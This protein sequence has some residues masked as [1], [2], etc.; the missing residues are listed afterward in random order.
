MHWCPPKTESPAQQASQGFSSV[1]VALSFIEDIIRCRFNKPW[2]PSSCHPHLRTHDLWMHWGE[3]CLWLLMSQMSSSGTMTFL[4]NATVKQRHSIQGWKIHSRICGCQIFTVWTG[5][6]SELQSFHGSY[7][8][9]H[10][11]VQPFCFDRTHHS[12]IAAHAH[13]LK[14]RLLQTLNYWV[15]SAAHLSRQNK[16]IQLIVC[17]WFL[18]QWCA[19]NNNNNNLH[20]KYLRTSSSWNEKYTC[21]R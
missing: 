7:Y 1:I 20:C 10:D 16:F 6:T 18:Q 21:I 13:P 9:T 5:E 8:D 12:S 11:G 3:H 4:W 2:S 17:C 19:K 15:P 14:R